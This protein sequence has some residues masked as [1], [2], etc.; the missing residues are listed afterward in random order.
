MIF[1]TQVKNLDEG[2]VITI[3]KENF[4]IIHKKEDTKQCLIQKIF[5]GV[6][7]IRIIDYNEYVE[8]DS[9]SEILFEHVEK[10]EYGKEGFIPKCATV[11]SAAYDFYTPI[12][13]EIKPGEKKMIWTNIKARMPKDVL[14]ML[15]VRSSFGKLNLMFANTIGFVDSDYYNNSSNEGNIGICLY[16]YGKETRK[17]KRGDRIGQG[18]FVPIFRSVN[19]NSKKVRTG[20]F[21]STDEGDKK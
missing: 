18:C 3:N 15:N 14:L 1:K 6:E 9:S 10:I 4:S 12:D 19:G 2:T 20:G 5:P 11:G 21:G 13:V 8:V 16:N 7:G 17:F